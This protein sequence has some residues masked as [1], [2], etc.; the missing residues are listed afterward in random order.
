MLDL[1]RGVPGY[2]YPVGRLDY[3][4]EGLLLVTNDGAFAARLM[5]PRHEV[6]KVYRVRVRGVPDARALERL[7]AGSRSTVIARRRLWSGCGKRFE[8]T[9]GPEVGRR[10]D[11]A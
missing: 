6:A 10:A 9:R 1:L 7:T 8:G 11:A 5:H 4:S 3:D 2:L